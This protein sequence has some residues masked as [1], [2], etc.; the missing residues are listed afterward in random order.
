M[1]KNKKFY[2]LKTLLIIHKLQRK[3]INCSSIFCHSPWEIVGLRFFVNVF[4]GFTNLHLFYLPRSYSLLNII[5]KSVY[6]FKISN[7][8]FYNFKKF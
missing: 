5:L 3:C 4:K 2:K 6:N 1:Y 8:S 7:H